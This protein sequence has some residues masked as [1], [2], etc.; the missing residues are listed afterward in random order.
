[1]EVFVLKKLNKN[2]K[3]LSGICALIVAVALV[4]VGVTMAAWRASTTVTNVVVIGDVSIELV[5]V[6][7][8]VTG[9]DGGMTV[10]KVVSVTNDGTNSCYVR[11]YVK[12]QWYDASGKEVTAP[13]T[14]LILPN[15]DTANWVKGTC[16]SS[17]YDECWYYQ[18]A[19]AS[20]ETASSLFETFS[21]DMAFSAND[22][23]E[24]QGAI[25]V[26]AE[27]VQSD[28][29]SSMLVYTGA[30]ITGWNITVN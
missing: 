13:S 22:Y 14:D 20:G 23:P 10:D 27:A 12:K 26:Y 2:R 15:Y 9:L 30:S 6:Y 7:E 1:M 3:F 21:L 19:L 4:S 29:F 28:Q 17:E 11:V 24:Y 8:P 16:A 5:D 18:T 25:T